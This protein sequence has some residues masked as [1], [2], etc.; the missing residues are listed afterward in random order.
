[1]CLRPF[2]REFLEFMGKDFEIIVFAE[3]LPSHCQSI[4]ETLPGVSHCLYRYHAT[5]VKGKWVK[6]VSRLGRPLSHLV[7]IDD[8]LDSCLLN[9]DN[10][11]QITEW[12]GKSGR[13]GRSS[14]DQE[15]SI[16]GLFLSKMVKDKP[17]DV[18]DYLSGYGSFRE[19]Y[20]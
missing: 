16:L 20:N 12:T 10:S 13:S 6:D 15:L 3:S 17:L 11:M 19:Q 4:I 5:R 18:R 2:A 9:G 14:E 8:H 1:M 7:M